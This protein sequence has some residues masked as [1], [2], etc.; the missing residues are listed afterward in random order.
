MW[1][2]LL[3]RDPVRVVNLREEDHLAKQP[4]SGI[5]C[6]QI[7]LLQL[8][9][10]K[11]ADLAMQGKQMKFSECLGIRVPHVNYPTTHHNSER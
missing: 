6:L 11:E 4:V 2:H 1:D 7:L 9:G 5:F 3:S 8:S 10:P